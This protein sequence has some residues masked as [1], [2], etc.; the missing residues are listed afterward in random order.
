MHEKIIFCHYGK[1][2]GV[3]VNEYLS[4]MLR[5]E[6]Y[7]IRNAFYMNLG[8]DFTQD[9]VMKVADSCS[10]FK[11][12][13]HQQHLSVTGKALRYLRERGYWSFTFLRR[14]EEVICSIYFWALR[15]INDG[16]PC[17]IGPHLNPLN[18]SLGVFFETVSKNHKELW[19]IPPWLNQVDYVAM[20][21]DN[22]FRDFL[23]SEFS[24]Q[25]DPHKYGMKE[26][27]RNRSSNLGFKAYA[28]S[29]EISIAQQA[30]LISTDEFKEFNKLIF[31][32]GQYGE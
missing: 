10:D 21:S 18:I 22:N 29:G 20:I 15:K 25:Y 28:E 5:R 27:H 16:H 1:A 26:R 31:N 6:G 7:T 8:R 19:A 17:P 4:L 11:T 9:E 2:G 23:E 24:H 32:L 12:F 3:W 14:P 13:I 30:A